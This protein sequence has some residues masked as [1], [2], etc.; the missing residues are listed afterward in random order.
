MDIYTIHMASEAMHKFFGV[1]FPLKPILQLL[2]LISKAQNLAKS[3]K[4]LISLKNRKKIEM[5]NNTLQELQF[6]VPKTV[7][8]SILKHIEDIESHASIVIMYGHGDKNRRI[9]K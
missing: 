4:I 6:F 8:I 7:I 3:K 5:S 9:S 2:N 1:L